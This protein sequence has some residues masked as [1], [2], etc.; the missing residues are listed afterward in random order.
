MKGE[1]PLGHFNLRFLLWRCQG[2]SVWSDRQSSGYGFG[3][4]AQV[5]ESHGMGEVAQV[6]EVDRAGEG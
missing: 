3:N 2:D 4:L 5:T 6:E 1:L